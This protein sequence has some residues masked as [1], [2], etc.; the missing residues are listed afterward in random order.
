[1]LPSAIPGWASSVETW[2]LTFWKGRDCAG[3]LLDI[4]TERY[5]TTWKTYDKLLGDV[6]GTKNRS[7]LESQHRLVTL[8][9]REMST[10]C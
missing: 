1:M 7:R 6:V 2:C 4:G 9:T 8:Q 5:G 3:D 10:E